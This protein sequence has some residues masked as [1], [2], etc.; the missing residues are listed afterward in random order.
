MKPFEAKEQ[1]MFHNLHVGIDKTLVKM[2]KSDDIEEIEAGFKTLAQLHKSFDDEKVS[3]VWGYEL[4]RVLTFYRTVKKNHNDIEVPDLDEL[5]KAIESDIQTK[6]K[7][8]EL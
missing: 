8:E 7:E 5:V 3:A 1:K 2:M 6:E 4:S